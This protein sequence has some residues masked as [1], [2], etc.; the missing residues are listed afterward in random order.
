[1]STNEEVMPWALTEVQSQQVAERQI[2]KALAKFAEEDGGGPGGPLLKFKKDEH[3][4]LGADTVPE[5]TEFIAFPQEVRKGWSKF[6]NKQL[7]EEKTG[8][9]VAGFVVPER[10]ELGDL[11]KAKWPKNDAGQPADP[12]VMQCFLPL[13]NISTG[14]IV[15]FVSSSHGGRSAIATLCGTAARNLHRGNPRIRLRVGSYKHQ[16]FGRVQVPEFTVI[17]WDTPPPAA[18]FNDEISSI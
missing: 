13:E 8:K 16:K 14:Q 5:G 11:D 7:V 18:E 3:F 2:A 1:M 15:V 9:P 12:W 4:I 10:D 17:G 6:H